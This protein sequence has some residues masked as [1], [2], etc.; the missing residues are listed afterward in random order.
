MR[1]QR[2]VEIERIA[3]DGRAEQRRAHPAAIQPQLVGHQQHVLDCAAQALDGHGCLGGVAIGVGV[4]IQVAQ[5]QAWDHDRRRAQDALVRFAPPQLDRRRVL[6][7]HCQLTPPFVA[8]RVG[9]ALLWRGARQ[10]GEAPGQAAMRRWRPARRLQ[11][12]LD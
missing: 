5:V 8:H 2:W 3:D 4:D 11:H 6:P 9:Q 12:L 1:R 10:H 7:I